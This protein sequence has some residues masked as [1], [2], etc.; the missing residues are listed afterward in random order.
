MRSM[1]LHVV[2]NLFVRSQEVG[3]IP[4][5]DI[6]EVS[7]QSGFFGKLKKK[8]KTKK[9]TKTKTSKHPSTQ[10]MLHLVEIG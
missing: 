6:P 8:N 7:L 1:G 10:I 3:L 5:D 2:L 4:N 9:K